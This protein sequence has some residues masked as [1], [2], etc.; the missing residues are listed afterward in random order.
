MIKPPFLRIACPAHQPSF[1]ENYRD[2]E[3]KSLLIRVKGS[4]VIGMKEYIRASEVGA[5]VEWLSCA[6]SMQLRSPAKSLDQTI[7][8]ML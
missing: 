4:Q 6:F 2:A 3:P 7:L 5:R 8:F 1:W